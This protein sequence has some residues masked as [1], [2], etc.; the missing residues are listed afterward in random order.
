M[1]YAIISYII[2]SAILCGLQLST[3]VFT[4]RYLYNKLKLNWFGAWFLSISVMILN[5]ALYITIIVAAIVMFIIWLFTV[6][7]KD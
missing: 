2:I 5:G 7:H 6:G 1:I 3:E 4:P